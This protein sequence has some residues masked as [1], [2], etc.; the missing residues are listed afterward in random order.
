MK[1]KYRFKEINSNA[2]TIK[3][4]CGT[5]D[6]ITLNKS[7][8]DDDWNNAINKDY[9]INEAQCGDLANLKIAGAEDHT[10]IYEDTV[11]TKWKEFTKNIVGSR[12]L[13]DPLVINNLDKTQP[14]KIYNQTDFTSASDIITLNASIWSNLGSKYTYDLSNIDISTFSGASTNLRYLLP[15]YYNS[16]MYDSATGENASYGCFN[17]YI[18]KWYTLPEDL[19]K[20][21]YGFA[22]CCNLK[23]LP[24][25]P[26][27]ITSACFA[28][29]GCTSL[30][31]IND[32]MLPNATS[33]EKMFQNCSGLTKV[34]NIELPKASCI[35]YMFSGC[36]FSEIGNLNLPE[37]TQMNSLFTG[38]TKLEKIGDIYAPKATYI[39]N[40]L[41]DCSALTTIFPL[42][43]STFIS[44]LSYP[45]TSISIKTLLSFS[46]IS[47]FI[48]LSFSISLNISSKNILLGNINIIFL[49]YF[50]IFIIT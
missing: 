6:I 32:I 50:Q 42:L 38:N 29:Y 21:D 15:V 49:S 5:E 19:P 10:A 28:F 30:T 41:T 4:S 9:Y 20:L 1:I 35:Y 31:E 47:H 22:Y 40:W 46:K 27:S 26:K 48:L 36:S 7:D 23:E 17:Y 16:G 11:N 8:F 13:A 39:T 37:C 44:F 24:D 14:V 43:H 2:D 25:I 3:V 34:G 33:T 18:T 12:H 45:G